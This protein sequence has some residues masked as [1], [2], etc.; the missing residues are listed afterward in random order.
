[1]DDQ[2]LIIVPSGIEIQLDQHRMD[3]WNTYNCTKWN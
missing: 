2:T 3:R 1:M